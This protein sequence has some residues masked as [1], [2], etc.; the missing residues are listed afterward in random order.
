M[1]DGHEGLRHPAGTGVLND[2]AAIDDT[3]SALFHEILGA[4]EDLSVRRFS[5]SPD[6]NG[7]STGDFDYLMIDAHIVRGIGLDDVGSKFDGLSNQ[8]EDLCRI[9]VDHI[10]PR[11]LIGL[12]HQGFNHQRHSVA[13]AV[14]F[15]LKNVLK[16]LIADL[17]LAGN[18]E[19]VDDDTRRIEPES[20]LDGVFNHAG[21]KRPRKFPSI[22]I[23]D[24]G[25]QNERRFVAS[26][27]ILQERC[28]SDGE[29][30]GVGRGFD[31]GSNGGFEVFDA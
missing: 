15:D 6:Q 12:E 23:G 1:D 4:L 14:G 20:L 5:P 2:V 30:N 7:Y 8:R 9:T 13:V 16:A 26:R 25:P 21:K 10:A 24:V 22:D 29:L 3:G 18:P 27:Q 11:P 17:R 28:L 31:E 19:E